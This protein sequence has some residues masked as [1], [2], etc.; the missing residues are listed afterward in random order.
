MFMFK[1]LV[2]FFHFRKETVDEVEANCDK[3]NIQKNLVHRDTIDFLK[4][5]LEKLYGNSTNS[6]FKRVMKF[7]EDISDKEVILKIIRIIALKKQAALM[8]N[9]VSND[10]VF[11]EKPNWFNHVFLNRKRN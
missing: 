11:N 4:H 6:T 1:Q 8:F 5:D 3:S 2:K 9:I 7:C 10:G